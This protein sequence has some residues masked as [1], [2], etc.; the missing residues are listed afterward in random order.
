MAGGFVVQSLVAYWFHQRF[1]VSLEQLGP[2]FF[3]TNL[4]SALS[5]LAAAALADRFGLLNT[6]VFTHLPSNVLLAL[7]PFMPSWPVAAGVLLARHA[8][9]QMDVPTRQAYTMVLVAP[10][11]RAAAAGLT[12]AVRPAASSLAPAISGAALQTAA[13]GLPFV[14]AG[15][16]KILYDITLWLM[17]RRASLGEHRH[18]GTSS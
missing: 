4:L 10:D 17:F 5:A 2:L 18:D 7:V 9:S 8:L 3:G 11:K 16:L 14:L 13:N 12:N 1:G 6:M 15:G